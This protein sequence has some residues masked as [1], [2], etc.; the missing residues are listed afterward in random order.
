MNVNIEK[1]RPRDEKLSAKLKEVFHYTI[2]ME[3][4][5][6]GLCYSALCTHKTLFARPLY[7]Q[8]IKRFSCN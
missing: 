4:L 8:G 3:K 7:P 2:H 1:V 6:F 5:N